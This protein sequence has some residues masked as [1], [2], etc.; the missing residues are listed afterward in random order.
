MGEPRQLHLAGFFSAGNVTH[1]H[2]AWRHIGATNGFLTGD[3]YKRIARTLERGKFDLLFLPDAL[4][5]ED[6]Y[7]ENLDIG[8]GLGGQGAI[9]LE[10]KSVVATMAA[11]TERLGLGATVSTTY[12]PPYHVARIFATLDHLSGGRVSWNVVTSLNDSEARNF[13]V[14]EHLE[15]DTRYD[16]AD[17]FLEV[18]RK[19]W[20]SWDDDALLLDKAGGRF[21]GPKKVQYLD[22]RGKYL[23]VRGPLQV[24]R[25]RQGEPVIL[26]AGLSPRGRKFAG[27]W[28]EAV[29]SISPN[30]DVM[31]ATYQDIK[32]N[33]AAAGR[34]PDKTKVFTAVMPVLGD[35]ESAA[36]DRLQYA[37][38]LVHPQVGLSTLSSHSG[39][40]LSIYPL[41][42]RYSE[43]VGDLRN[44]QVPTM[45]QMFS[46]TAGGD[47][48]TLA[49]LGSRYGTNVGFVPQWAGTAEQIADRLTEYFQAGAADG[50]IISAA[51]LPGTY[52]EFVD[53]V[54]PLLQERG[55]FRE[56]Y[57]GSTLREHLGIDVPGFGGIA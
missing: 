32:A 55:V 44:R 5:V 47:N 10:P 39:I 26:Q 11:V 48:L 54:V 3:Y 35:T 12:Y 2:G 31:R 25:S 37:N 46:A 36:K 52:D 22:H 17:E 1:A 24:P 34:D 30:L 23:S 27:R 7:G 49:E 41:D 13:G 42:T 18:V 21:A 56:E 15:H 57:S 38:S 45:L 8:V 20:S 53:Q 50:L 43:I 9:A 6:S 16:R 14:D 29:F 33:V 4:A 28:A 40:D 51:Y 19:L